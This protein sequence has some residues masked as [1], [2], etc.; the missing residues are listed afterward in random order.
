VKRGA[1][2]AALRRARKTAKERGEALAADLALV[3][4]GADLVK[5]FLRG[6]DVEKGV[7]IGPWKDSEE[8]AKRGVQQLL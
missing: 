2:N 1:W 3:F 8:M 5:R 6:R 4:W 7:D